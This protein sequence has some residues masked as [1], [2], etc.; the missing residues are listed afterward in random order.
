MLLPPQDPTEKRHLLR[1]WMAPPAPYAPPLPE[2]YAEVMQSVTI[3]RRGGIVV[4]AQSETVPLEA[5]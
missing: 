3:G 5:E 1:L 4:P 2:C